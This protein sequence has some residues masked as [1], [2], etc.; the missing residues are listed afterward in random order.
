MT[1]IFIR[2]QKITEDR[3]MRLYNALI[4]PILTYNC[5]TWALTDTETKS[6]N[7]FHRKQLRILLGIFY[8]D[9][10]S[11]NELYIRC[12]TTTISS[13]ITKQR[14]QLFGHI[15]RRDENI[16]AQLAMNQYFEPGKKFRGRP[17]TTLP[18]TL[19]KDIQLIN[20]LLPP[21]SIANDHTYSTTTQQT[22]CR[23]LKS[24]QDLTGI[25]NLAQ[26]RKLWQEIGHELMTRREASHAKTR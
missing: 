23:Q 8:P 5:S 9:T 11:N 15:L 2:R 24:K 14:W 3:R 7:A 25:R 19:D 20:D 21:E 26:N 18:T 22:S 6:L 12:N 16:P 10:I 17:T 4:L 13:M 1:S